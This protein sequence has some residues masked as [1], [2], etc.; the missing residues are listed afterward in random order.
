MDVNQS[1]FA[2]AGTAATANAQTQSTQRAA[3]EDRDEVQASTANSDAVSST[4]V[5]DVSAAGSSSEG[6]ATPAAVESDPP[7]DTTSER[8]RPRGDTLDIS[9]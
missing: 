7:A 2:F 1:S 4:D 3:Q 9:V 5:G 6:Q 8:E